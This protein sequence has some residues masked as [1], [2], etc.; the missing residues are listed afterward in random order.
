MLREQILPELYTAFR[1]GTVIISILVHELSWCFQRDKYDNERVTDA[2][3]CIDG[4]I[5][6]SRV[7]LLIRW[8]NMSIEELAM[9]ILIPLVTGVGNCCAKEGLQCILVSSQWLKF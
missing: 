7:S 2:A 8:C 6:P 4:S 9:R 3:H 5:A 1:C